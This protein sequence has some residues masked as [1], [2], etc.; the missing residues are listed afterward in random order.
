MT[1]SIS[2]TRDNLTLSLF[3]SLLLVFTVSDVRSLLTCSVPL[4]KL[5][6]RRQSFF[7]SSS[8]FSSSSSSSST[9]LASVNGRGKDFTTPESGKLKKKVNQSEVKKTEP[10][11]SKEKMK[12]EKVKNEKEIPTDFIDGLPV[13]KIRCV[14]YLFFC[15]VFFCSNRNFHHC[16]G[17]DTLCVND[18]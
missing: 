14:V 18:F 6:N 4:R 17:C 13:R 8:S 11:I 12:N 2:L 5:F 1:R 16:N 7:F 9:F 15:I 10:E 3:Y